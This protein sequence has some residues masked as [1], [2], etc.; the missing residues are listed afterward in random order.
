VL[1]GLAAMEPESAPS[2]FGPEG[3][4]ASAP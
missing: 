1:L 2:G 4:Q 3:R